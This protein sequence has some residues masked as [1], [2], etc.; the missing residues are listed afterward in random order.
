M[1]AYQTTP[2]TPT[3]RPPPRATPQ[4]LRPRPSSSN[5]GTRLRRASGTS[6]TRR[7]TSEHCSMR[8]RDDWALDR[9][10]TGHRHT[11]RNRHGPAAWV[12]VV[13]LLLGVTAVGSIVAFASSDP[14][15]PPTSAPH[16]T[17]LTR[18]VR[19]RHRLPRRWLRRN[20]RRLW[21][22]APLSH[23]GQARP[24]ERLP[25]RMWIDARARSVPPS[26]TSRPGRSGPSIP[27]WPRRR[28]PL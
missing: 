3:P 11:R 28:P 23:R 2:T 12:V 27:A 16:P 24:S 17:M 20:H 13:A 18:S 26:R 9:A 19:P 4:P 10:V 25:P 7:A 21:L 15:R 14:R 22:L 1:G 6:G 5:C 8:H